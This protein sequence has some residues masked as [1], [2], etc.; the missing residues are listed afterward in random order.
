M[1]PLLPFANFETPEG[2]ASIANLWRDVLHNTFFSLEKDSEP[3]N[4]ARV[5]MLSKAFILHPALFHAYYEL[6]GFDKP[7]AKPAERKLAPTIIASVLLMVAKSYEV[8]EVFDGYAFGDWGDFAPCHSADSSEAR[9]GHLVT[10]LNTPVP[11]VVL[12][13]LQ[14][15][16]SDLFGKPPVASQILQ[17]D[18]KGK[19]PARMTSAK[20]PSFLA[21]AERFCKQ[22]GISLAFK[23]EQEDAL[24][25]DES[26]TVRQAEVEKWLTTL[27]KGFGGFSVVTAGTAVLHVATTGTFYAFLMDIVVSSRR[28]RRLLIEAPQ[29]LPLPPKAPAIP[30][31]DTVMRAPG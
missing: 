23:K 12:E 11:D 28:K 1:C 10:L 16:S 25:D 15:Y 4:I 19:E 20:K 9:V 18:E 30:K 7:K 24:I 29:F 31:V 8:T 14:T 21:L 2:W 17:G 5:T 22:L 26:K 6:C 3:V 27:K 13:A